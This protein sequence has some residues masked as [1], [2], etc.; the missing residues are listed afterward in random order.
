MG[1]STFIPSRPFVFSGKMVSREVATKKQ[2]FSVAS[3]EED[4]DERRLHLP[5]W[6]ESVTRVRARVGMPI[7]NE[8][9]IES[10]LKTHWPML[11]EAVL[12]EFQ[13]LAFD[14]SLPL[15]YI[16]YFL[17]CVLS[18]HDGG[19]Y[20]HSLPPGLSLPT[21]PQRAAALSGKLFAADGYYRVAYMPHRP[22]PPGFSWEPATAP[23]AFSVAWPNTPCAF[24]EE[25]LRRARTEVWERLGEQLT[26]FIRAGYA[27][28]DTEN[29]EE[30]RDGWLFYGPG[31]ED[32]TPQE[33]LRLPKHG[34]VIRTV[35]AIP[36]VLFPNEAYGIELRGGALIDV[37]RQPMVERDPAIDKQD[38]EY[39]ER[40]EKVIRFL[41]AG[42]L[43]PGL[44]RGR[45]P[46]TAPAPGSG[47]QRYVEEQYREEL[48]KWNHRPPN[49]ELKRMR[50]TV[51]RRAQ[52]QFS[53]EFRQELK[54]GWYAAI[55]AEKPWQRR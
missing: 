31:V 33:V 9:E 22:K 52:R 32:R 55:E 15:R 35:V 3:G 43:L 18:H 5:A 23:R 53:P 37:W 13:K 34:P 26:W 20:P 28:L 11:R 12:E 6:I 16:N 42:P 47:Y 1:L 10:W 29:A 7:G 19:T 38:R 24:D 21:L 14:T 4:M 8:T 41:A 51:L 49:R 45:L 50:K 2:I 46:S 25:T 36:V 40:C 30:W 48:K 44:G 54:P 39:A 17:S 27:F